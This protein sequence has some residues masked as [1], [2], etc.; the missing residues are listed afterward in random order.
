MAIIDPEG[1]FNGDRLRRCSNIAQLHF[2]RLFLASDGNARLEINYARIIGRAYPTFD[3]IPSSTEL[4]S[5][6]QEYA[7]NYLL[8]VFEVDGQLW[9]QW[10]TNPKFLPRFK[11]ALDRRSPIPPESAFTQWKRRYR[12]ETKSLPKSFQNISGAFPCGVGVGVK[13]FCASD[14]A[15]VGELPS[16]DNPPFDPTPSEGNLLPESSKFKAVK[17]RP[18]P[19][20]ELN[21]EQ[22]AWFDE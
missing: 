5:F 17:G 18:T 21:P 4:Q 12:E 7:K 10:D 16:I 15:R 20:S 6:I 19:C 8:F 9:G 13:T 2:P 3:P 1:L 22:S 11:T 14:D